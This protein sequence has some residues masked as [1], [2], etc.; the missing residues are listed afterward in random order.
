RAWWPVACR[1]SPE[2][3][4]ANTREPAGTATISR[5]GCRSLR[6]IRTR[7]LPSCHQQADLLDARLARVEVA[8]DR[9]LVHDGDPVGERED[10]VEVLADQE[11]PDSLAGRRPQVLVHR[12][13]GADVEAAGRRCSDDELRLPGELPREHDFLEVPAG[14][15]PGRRGRSRRGDAVAADQLDRALT[16]VPQPQQRSTRH[17]RLAVRPEDEV[18]GDA[19]ARGPAG[20]EPVPR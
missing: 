2:A 13:D 6:S 14:E 19:E 1:T 18:R 9:A 4:N 17:V 3:K 16:D 7:I 20:P 8:E 5:R 12:L 10:L 15:E 11:H